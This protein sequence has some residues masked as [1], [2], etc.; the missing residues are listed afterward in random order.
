MKVKVNW[1]RFFN[2]WGTALTIGIVLVMV[3][4]WL[5]VIIKHGAPSPHNWFYIIESWMAK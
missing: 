4:M 3:G 2:F 1:R 5:D